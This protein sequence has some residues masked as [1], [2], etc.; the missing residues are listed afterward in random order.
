MHR[1]RDWIRPVEHPLG[2]DGRWPSGHFWSGR[3]PSTPR[4]NPKV[5]AR[6]HTGLDI[7][8]VLGTPLL[9]PDDGWFDTWSFNSS[10]GYVQTVKHQVRW[11]RGT[12]YLWSRH[13]HCLGIKVMKYTG[14][15]VE[16]GETIAWLGSTGGSASPH[17]HTA[18]TLTALMP[19]TQAGFLDPEPVYYPGSCDLMQ[20]GYPYPK[21]VKKLQRRLNAVGYT[22]PLT[23]DGDYGPAT[24]RA[25]K[26]YQGTVALEPTGAANELCLALL[27]D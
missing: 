10:G 14:Q 26:W 17:D 8:G 21:D 20:R 23:I 6:P 3:Q 5:N 4:Y 22:P 24:E 1:L 11:G 12:L 9:A 18:I 27:F 13:C 19:T 16:Q 2:G 25:V 15:L 7:A